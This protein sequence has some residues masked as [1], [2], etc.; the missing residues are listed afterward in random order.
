MGAGKASQAG[1]LES[2]DSLEKSPWDPIL[3]D[4]S[5]P[6]RRRVDKRVDSPA[7]P[8]CDACQHL[9]IAGK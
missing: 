3:A 4:V 7:R 2:F 6:G 1:W 9:Q 8:A 5:P